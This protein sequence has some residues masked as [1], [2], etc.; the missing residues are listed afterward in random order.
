MERVTTNQL[1]VYIY[2]SPKRG[3]VLSGDTYSFHIEE[4]FAVFAI[5]D[6]LGNGPDALASSEIIP[7][8]LKEYPESSLEELLEKVNQEMFGK[9]GAAV[10]FVK[11]DFI[12]KTITY[13]CI[14]NIRM[15]MYHNREK[16]IYPLPQTGYLSGKKI[17]TY[18][19]SYPYQMGDLFYLHS[20]GVISKSPKE[21]FLKSQS[22]YELSEFVR[23]KVDDSDDATFIAG[24]L[25]N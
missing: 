10:A 6:G 12:E 14:G 23:L 5:A 15:Y 11:I 16:M 22:A 9:R 21:Q 24:Q 20:D 8:V 1:D 7:R 19:Q 18:T 4:H 2:N 17:K 13:S 3:N 25:L